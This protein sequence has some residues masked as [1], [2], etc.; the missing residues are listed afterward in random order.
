MIE[1]SAVMYSVCLLP[2]RL[3]RLIGVKGMCLYKRAVWRCITVKIELRPVQSSSYGES[4]GH[5]L[6]V[7]GSESVSSVGEHHVHGC[8]VSGVFWGSARV[9]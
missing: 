1:A 5:V 6:F 3:L 9:A 4:L 8:F 7:T 2:K